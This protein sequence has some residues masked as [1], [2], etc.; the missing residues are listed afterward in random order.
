MTIAEQLAN[1]DLSDEVLHPVTELPSRA[2]VVIVGGGIIGSSIAYHLTR[3][4]ET[5]VVMLE[6]GRLTNGTTWHAAGL[7]SQVRGTRALTELTRHNAETYERLPGETGIE[8]GLRRVGALTVAR[9]EGRMQEILYGV[10]MARDA[11][12]PV[13]VL[14]PAQV[15]DLWPGAVVDDLVGA[16]L[17][18]TDATVNPGDAALSFAK[19]AVD[20]GVRYVPETEVTGFVFDGGRVTGA[21]YLARRHRGRDGRARVRPVDER[22]GAARRRERAPVPGRACVGDD[23]GGRGRRRAPAVPARPR[24]LPVHPPLPRAL[25]RRRVR[26]EGPAEAGRRDHDRRV[27]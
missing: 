1:R 23:G 15:K 7:V 22:A 4:G 20:A 6:R 17:F 8:T 11:G 21:Q 19:G 9:T 26:A 2:R 24:R 12:I 13:E 5:D 14:P 25:S 3:A 16:V 18:P 27:R 10:G